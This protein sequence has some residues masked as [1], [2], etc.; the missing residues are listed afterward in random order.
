MGFSTSGICFNITVISFFNHN[1]FWITFWSAYSNFFFSK[2]ETKGI[3]EFA[4]RRTRLMTGYIHTILDICWQVSQPVR[5][6][7][8][9]TLLVG[10]SNLVIV[11][12]FMTLY[13]LETYFF[14][15]I[16]VILTK[17]YSELLEQVH[18]SSIEVLQ[19]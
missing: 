17:W 7:V 2:F 1:P 5:Y 13:I 14:W 9:V 4:K 11:N 18:S 12:V 15:R 6:Y 3:R 16:K 19:S 8:G 10:V